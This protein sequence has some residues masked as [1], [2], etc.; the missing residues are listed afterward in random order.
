MDLTAHQQWPTTT[1]DARPLIA[2]INH[3]HSNIQR[4]CGRLPADVYIGNN[5][6]PC[7]NSLPA[8]RPTGMTDWNFGF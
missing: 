1:A 3:N 8:K 4:A 5:T 2:S 6:S 7:I